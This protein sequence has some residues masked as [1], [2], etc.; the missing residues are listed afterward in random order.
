[1]PDGRFVQHVRL[2]D[3]D[4]GRRPAPACESPAL[5][6]ESLDVEP[7]GPVPGGVV[8]DQEDGI[9]FIQPE[10]HVTPLEPHR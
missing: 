3:T 2:W 5:T 6:I 10:H 1:M 8:E 4:G 7:V 9:V